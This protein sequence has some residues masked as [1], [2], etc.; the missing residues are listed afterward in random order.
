ML[1]TPQYLR[2]AALLVG[3]IPRSPLARFSGLFLQRR[4][5]HGA[6]PDEVH[7]G[8]SGAADGVVVH[9]HHFG[10]DL[11]AFLYQHGVALV[12]VELTH[13]GLVVERGPLDNGAGQQDGIH[14]G[15]RRHDTRT[16][17][18]IRHLTK[19]GR[20]LLR[21][22]FVGDGPSG[23]LGGHAEGFLLRQRVDFQ[24]D[25]V[26]GHRQRPSRFVPVV[27]VVHHLLQRVAQLHVGA[28]F[29]APSFGG[30]HVVVVRIAGNVVAQKIVEIGIQ[31]AL[32]THLGVF[33]LE[34]A[35]GGVAGIGKE[36]L[37]ALLALPVEPLEVGPGQQYL[38]ANLERTLLRHLEGDAAYGA[39]VGRHVVAFGAVAARQRPNQTSAF[40][41]QRDAQSVV[42]QLAAYLELLPLKSFF[43]AAV[44]IPDF[45]FVIRIRERDHRTLVRHRL[46]A[47]VE[48]AA[49][50]PCGRIG[51]VH[52]GVQGLQPL[53]LVHQPVKLHVGD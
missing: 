26:G 29:E 22:K 39:H 16:S 4:T 32:G 9:R 1:Y 53:E 36:L 2:L 49:D 18:L 13:E 38:A 28:H 52:F 20:G 46:E 51:V 42:F 17:H 48:I 21:L 6:S 19:D 45:V 31:P 30:H 5:A 12:Q 35:R 7:L 15:H 37:F 24:H 10:D 47:A 14:V 40:V 50:A 34:R 11:A 8:P 23:A 44:E 41:V 3:A 43:N 33:A 25:A 27:D